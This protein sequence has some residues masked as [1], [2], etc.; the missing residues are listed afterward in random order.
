VTSS[1]NSSSTSFRKIL[2][3]RFSAIGDIVL[4]SPVIRCLKKQTD[5]QV[6]YLTKYR[7]RKL[8]ENNPYVDKVWTIHKRVREV[9]PAL[10]R[11]KFDY[12]IDLHN[13]LRTLLIK[14]NLP[15]TKSYSFN[16][17][18]I[19]KWLLVHFK[20]NRLP[21]IHI[22]DRYMQTV[23]PLKVVNDG[24]GLDFFMGKMPLPFPVTL[25]K[26]YLALVIGAGKNTKA[27]T[28]EQLI[29]VVENS[30]L[31]P[32]LLGG[33]A[34]VAKATVIASAANKTII[35]L[36]GQLSLVQSAYCV[37]QA[38]KVVTGDT[39]LMHIAAAFHK[40][41]VSVWGNTVPKLGMTPYYG[42]RV[43]QNTIVEVNGLP[44][45]P[46]SKI[47]FEECPKG[48]FRCI[49]ELDL[50]HVLKPPTQNSI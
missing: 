43:D 32:I 23:A 36:V 5:F 31:L 22:V 48:H 3:I 45:R 14:L 28:V 29:K 9:L 7:F 24:A 4:T 21:S 46:C 10:R 8:V 33:S 27:L 41:I 35:N 49:K 6:H 20:I 2:I 40:P 47:G 37:Q 38:T 44:C 50:G 30:K 12:I 26:F 18:N 15:F 39:G 25:P 42:K 1:P 13:N 11:E 34:E 16:K 17:L 19:E